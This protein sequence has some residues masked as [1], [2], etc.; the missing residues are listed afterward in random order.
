MQG[1]AGPSLRTPAPARS[2]N[3]HPAGAHNTASSSQ[4]PRSPAPLPQ[5]QQRRQQVVWYGPPGPPARA[6]VLALG[7]P[8]RA[9]IWEPRPGFGPYPI[10][11][12]P[13]SDAKQEQ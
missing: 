3:G 11:Q 9:F 5:Q 10:A 8:R 2:G 1:A 13:P 6:P 12:G 4:G 7:D